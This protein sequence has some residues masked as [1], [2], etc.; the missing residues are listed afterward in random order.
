MFYAPGLLYLHLPRTGGTFVADLLDKQKLGSRQ[1]AM[2]IGGHDGIRSVPPQILASSLTFGS[3]RDP[4]SWYASID[5]HYRNRGRF[6]GFLHEMFGKAVPFKEVV[7]GFTCPR[8]MQRVR[9]DRPVRFPGARH[10]E[11]RFA[12]QLAESGVGLYTW[13]VM[14]MFCSE[15]LETVP[16]LVGILED[17]DDIPWGV[18]AIVD[19]AQLRD[20]LS[21]VLQAWRPEV[22][23]DVDPVLR[24]HPAQNEKARF[25]GVTPAGQP[26]PSMYDQEAQEW[27]WK[28][29]GWMMRRFGF[30]RP[31]GQR[32]AV[33]VLGR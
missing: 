18:Q 24:T 2:E 1:L 20:G 25:R 10:P 27:V 11:E 4:W 9:L 23:A 19:T 8:T 28:A 16:G 22:A 31:V 12:Q 30:D 15:P 17:F 7:R 33:T 14:R 29:D 5:A 26:D 3:L 32:P 6:D 13:M 21:T